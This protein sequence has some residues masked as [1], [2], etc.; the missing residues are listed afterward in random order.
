MN[1]VSMKPGPL[2]VTRIAAS[3][4]GAPVLGLRHG[5]PEADQRGERPP[6]CV[7]NGAAKGPCVCVRRGGYAVD[8]TPRADTV[9]RGAR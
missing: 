9:T 6:N 7:W 2:P 5:A 8:T 4:N 1:P 3:M